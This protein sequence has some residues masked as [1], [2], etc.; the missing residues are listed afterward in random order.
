MIHLFNKLFGSW[1]F[2]FLL[3]LCVVG[4]S[5]CVSRSFTLRFDAGAHLNPDANLQA[6]P[7]QVKVIQLSDP[8]A[9]RNAAFDDLWQQAEQAL[10]GSYISAKSFMVLPGS[11]KT[12]TVDMSKQ[13]KYIG[14]VAVF[15]THSG[16]VWRAIESVPHAY[17]IYPKFKVSLQGHTIHVEQAVF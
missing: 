3:V 2:I 16:Y 6:L 14:F 1:R 17:V 8:L 9:F 13:A 7:V 10:G 15:R 12:V 4:L 5:S 11:S